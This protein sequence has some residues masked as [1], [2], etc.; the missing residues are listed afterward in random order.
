KYYCDNML[1]RPDSG[2]SPIRLKMTTTANLFKWPGMIA[3][4]MKAGHERAA[5]NHAKDW[6]KKVPKKFFQEG[7]ILHVAK[8]EGIP[9][10]LVKKAGAEVADDYAGSGF[11]D[12]ARRIAERCGLEEKIKEIVGKMIKR[13]LKEGHQS[14][15]KGLANSYG[16]MDAYERAV[17]EVTEK[18]IE[19]DI[20]EAKKTDDPEKRTEILGYLAYHLINMERPEKA[21]KV[22]ELLAELVP[23]HARWAKN[24]IAELKKA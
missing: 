16:I 3:S 19:R 13:E 6:I 22:Y 20:A 15:A 18:R 2:L 10:E 8:S 11:L 7:A 1:K 24:R 12:E 14:T 9:E 17:D 21:K 23:E 5:I 4:I